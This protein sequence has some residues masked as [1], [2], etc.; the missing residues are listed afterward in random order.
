MDEMNMPLSS[1][2]IIVT[3]QEDQKYW[4]LSSEDGLFSISNVEPG[5]YQIR[6]SCMGQ[7]AKT[8]SIKIEKENIELG[9]VILPTAKYLLQDVYVDK[10]LLYI[11]KPPF[12][13]GRGPDIHKQN[14][15]RYAH[16]E[17]KNFKGQWQWQ[18]PTGDTV[19]NLIFTD[20]IILKR[21]RAKLRNP[22]MIHTPTDFK[23]PTTMVH[24]KFDFLI[25]W[26]ELIINDS[27]I[28][29]NIPDDP[30]KMKVKSYNQL[31]KSNLIVRFEQDML[32]YTIRIIQIKNPINKHKGYIFMTL[33]DNEK[34]F[35]LW[36]AHA[37]IKDERDH[38]VLGDADQ[39]LLGFPTKVI[40][41]RIE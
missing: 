37:L 38:V 13:P 27:V 16:P 22:E 18:S 25:G 23:E 14:F 30:K 7:Q 28:V 4:G 20:E 9:N 3:Q 11:P 15:Y 32:P 41:K 26:Y 39:E 34:Q 2:H 24:A 19:F 35:A 6:F 40:L 5:E 36:N 8:L 29:S 17:Y 10:Q 21:Y 31:K 1:V 33:L 12:N